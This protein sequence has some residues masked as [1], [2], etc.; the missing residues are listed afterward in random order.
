MIVQVWSGR[1]LTCRVHPAAGAGGPGRG[2][3][4]ATR[5]GVDAELHQRPVV[6]VGAVGVAAGPAA[7]AAQLDRSAAGGGEVDDHLDP[8]GRAE[9]DPAAPHRPRQKAA[10]GADLDQRRAVGEV[11]VVGAE[12]RD[13]EDP[14]A[15][16]ARLDPVVGQEGAVDE[17]RGAERSPSSGGRRSVNGSVSW[18]SRSKLRSAIASARSRAPP[19][20]RQRGLELVV[21]DPHPRQPVPGVQ[22]GPVEAVVVVPLERG[23]FGAPVFGQVV[24][25]AFA[26]ARLDQQVVAGAGATGRAGCCSSRRT[27]GPGQA[28][29]LA[30]ELGAVVAAVQVDAQFADLVGQFVVEGDLGPLAR[31]AADR[32]PGEAAAEGPEPGLAAG[33]DLLLGERGSGSR[34]ARRSAPAGSAAG[35]G[36]DRGLGRPA[37]L[38]QESAR[39]TPPPGRAG[40]ERAAAEGAEEGSAPQAGR[41][42]L[43]RRA[44]AQ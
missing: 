10:V 39:P 7:G 28:A 11:E 5:S 35:R 37:P 30:V 21:D 29:G 20:Q 14:Q 18:L 27:A 26:P 34:A 40:E 36:R 16:A 44:A 13:V 2:S 12:L 1:S 19:R 4:S 24:D 6:G 23:P 32:R 15:V 9:Q 38:R 41:C 42:G 22:G 33:Q 3:R 31:R 25:V 17:D 43:S 8:L